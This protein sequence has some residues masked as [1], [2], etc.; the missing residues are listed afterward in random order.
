VDL[1]A[2]GPQKS[3]CRSNSGAPPDNP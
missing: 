2:E 1:N 3:L